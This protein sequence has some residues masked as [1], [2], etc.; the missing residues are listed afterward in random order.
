V[1]HGV[2]QI[3]DPALQ[4]HFIRHS[5]PK[6]PSQQWQPTSYPMLLL[7]AALIEGLWH[8]D[9]LDITINLP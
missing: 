4:Q 9:V 3:V 2:L 1:H 6:N 5:L 7:V 8:F